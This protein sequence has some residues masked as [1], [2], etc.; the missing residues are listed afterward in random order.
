VNARAASAHAAEELSRA[1]VP[2][3]AFEGELL[4]REAAALSRAAYFMGPALTGPESARLA[5]LVERRRQREPFAYING[6]R[7]FYGLSF[8]VGPGVLI[9]RPETEL[10][11]DIVLREASALPWPRIVDVG[12]GSGCV[13]ISV[14]SRYQSG[15][16]TA[17][18]ASAGALR[19][20]A[21]NAA[22]LAPGVRFVRGDLATAIARADIVAANLPY[23][24]SSAIASLEP[25][26]RDWEPR[27]AL[28]G[29][30]DGLDLIRRLIFDC[31]T[32]LRP[33][34]LAMEV[35]AGQAPAV[36]TLGEA[37]GAAAET[38]LDLAG[39][40]RVVCLRWA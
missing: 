3:P 5:T 17:V 21:A 10:L 12:T 20:A 38:H 31:A 13:A 29:G 7:E 30:E 36:A 19:V 25:E 32:R 2:D 40:E 23:I 22:R 24:P 33:R 18:D 4:T 1:G 35:G 28:D 9:P 15:D 34:L 27:L 6:G 14:R 11:V 16:I 37:V 8:A 26:V 39:I